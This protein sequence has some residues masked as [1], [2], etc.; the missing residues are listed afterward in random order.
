MV[1]RGIHILI[2]VADNRLL[3]LSRKNVWS[4]GGKPTDALIGRLTPAHRISNCY[5]A[6][7]RGLGGWVTPDLLWEASNA[8]S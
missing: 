1:C 6:Y 5:P 3:L 7:K 8:A 4:V 2:L